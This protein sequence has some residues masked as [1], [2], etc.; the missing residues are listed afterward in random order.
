MVATANMQRRI[1]ALAQTNV[2]YS[3]N[4]KTPKR[5]NGACVGRFSSNAASFDLDVA[6]S[7]QIDGE[8]IVD[9]VL[10]AFYCFSVAAF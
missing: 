10:L 4:A 2:K 7:T 6:H 3:P 9:N 1:D 8:L 5:Q